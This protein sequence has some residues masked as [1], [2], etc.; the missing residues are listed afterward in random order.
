[1]DGRTADNVCGELDGDQDEEEEQRSCGHF[2]VQFRGKFLLAKFK[3]DSFLG[4]GNRSGF[5]VLTT[6]FVHKIFWPIDQ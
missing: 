5:D 1:M 2:E 3:K 6:N 4:S